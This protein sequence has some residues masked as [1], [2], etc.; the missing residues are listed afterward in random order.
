MGTPYGAK[1]DVGLKR[2]QNEDRFCI[3]PSLG[4]YVVCD[5]MG[6]HKAGEV[7]SGLAVEV[8]QKHL[9]ENRHEGHAPLIGRYDAA[10]LPQTNRLASAIR[11]ANH[12]I[13]GE[14]QHHL[15]YARM[16][17]TVVSALISG[18]VLSF[19]HVGD[20]RL[21][22]IRGDSIQPLTTDHSLVVEQMRDGLLTEEEAER[23]AQRHIVT[24][25]LGV[26]ATVDVE[27]GELPV[28][29]GDVLLLCSDGLTRGVPSGDIVR[30]VH[31]QPDLQIA[32]E[33][34]I[35]LANA[36]GGEDNTTVILVACRNRTQ[37]SVWHR[38]R[39]LVCRRES[40]MWN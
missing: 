10:F 35:T 36:A 24:R 22:L 14:A 32:S 28:I 9:L 30:A 29:N 37:P 17:T 12:A 8:I 40:Q 18:Q 33:Q 34:L 20:S 6:G 39:D 21:Y 31:D 15:D 1:S 5:G 2:V 26:E 38:I 4:L 3:D 13:H 11:L 19:A 16:G 25:A 27:L 23:S 7:A